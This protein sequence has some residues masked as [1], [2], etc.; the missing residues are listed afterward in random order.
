M[1]TE[2]DNKVFLFC[3]CECWKIWIIPKSFW[4]QVKNRFNESE[5]SGTGTSFLAR[6]V[7]IPQNVHQTM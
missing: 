5:T 7:K 4:N 2:G 1:V 3:N 6:D